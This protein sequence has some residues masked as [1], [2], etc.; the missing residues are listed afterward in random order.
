MATDAPTD[1]DMKQKT[2]IYCKMRYIGTEDRL[3]KIDEESIFN[4]LE[5]FYDEFSPFMSEPLT[6]NK[7]IHDWD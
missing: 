7:K 2:E 3:Y 1:K 6:L 4:E 5:A